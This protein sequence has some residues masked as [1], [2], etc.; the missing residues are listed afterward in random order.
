MVD[1]VEVLRV[2]L[3]M[4]W[5]V[6]RSGRLRDAR[7]TGGGADKGRYTRRHNVVEITTAIFHH[8]VLDAEATTATR[9]VGM[10]G[11]SDGRRSRLEIVMICLQQ[12]D[13]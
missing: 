2:V 13:S 12:Y 7:E 11:K 8:F 4:V 5:S 6:D 1:T 3:W 10:K 9:R